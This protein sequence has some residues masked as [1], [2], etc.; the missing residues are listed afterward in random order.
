MHEPKTEKHTPLS[1]DCIEVHN[2]GDKR[3]SGED[4]NEQVFRITDMLQPF[5]WPLG[6]FNR[7]L[8]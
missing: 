3:M 2:Q 1:E 4:G 7:Q 6:S 8:A 5:P